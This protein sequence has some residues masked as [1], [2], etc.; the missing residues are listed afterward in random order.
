MKQP[1]TPA[2]HAGVDLTDEAAVD[3]SVIGWWQSSPIDGYH[4]ERGSSISPGI[5]GQDRT[6]TEAAKTLRAFRP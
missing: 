4:W 3:T 1:L 5:I 6:E 2:D